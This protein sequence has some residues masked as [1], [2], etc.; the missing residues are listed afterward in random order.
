MLSDPLSEVLSLLKPQS[1]VSAGFEAG[2][3]WAVRFED[4]MARIKC[5]AVTRGSCWLSVDGL[6]EP[7]RIE[8]GECFVLPRGR[9]FRLGSDLVT[10]PVDAD[11]IFPPRVA[12]D[13]VTLNGGGSFALVGSRFAIEGRLASLVL[14]GLPALVHVSG[15]TDRAVLL[16]LVEQMRREVRDRKAGGA[17]VAQHLAHMMLV[18]ALRLHLDDAATSGT[19]WYFALGDPQL[20]AAIEALHADPARRWTLRDLGRIAG[21]SRSAFALAFR[22]RVGETPIGYLQRWRMLLAAERLKQGAAVS[23]IASGLGYESES[24]FSNAFKRTMGCTPRSFRTGA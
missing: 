24:A 12:G 3:D 14:D 7:V 17:L 9:P 22:K 2:G 13:V 23:A 19:G 10:I 1:S 21:M 5:Y 15:A 8:A 11:T 6:T 16:W 4:P 20:A 18:Q